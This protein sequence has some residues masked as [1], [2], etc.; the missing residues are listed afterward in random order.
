VFCGCSS[1]VDQSHGFEESIATKLASRYSV[2][3]QEHMYSV[4]R[5]LKESSASVVFMPG[6]VRSLSDIVL[7]SQQLARLTYGGD[8]CDSEDAESKLAVPNAELMFV[9]QSVE[10]RRLYR[11]YGGLMVVLDAVYRAGRYP[12]PLF[13]LLVKSNVNYQVVGV[14]VLQQET[15]HGLVNALQ[16]IRRWNPDICPRYALVDFSEEELA[17]LEE[18]FPGFC[19]IS[20]SAAELVSDLTA[21][22][23]PR[24]C[25]ICEL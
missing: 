14:I 19:Q 15:Q 17:A 9:Y 10:M 18:T 20:V 23:Q 1:F 21:V 6:N 4:I 16:V 12:L 24:F 25:H 8:L 7:T 22:I 5:E 11:R 13:L 3:D 2:I